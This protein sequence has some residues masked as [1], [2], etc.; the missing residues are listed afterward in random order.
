[1][2]SLPSA[3]RD[4]LGLLSLLLSLSTTQEC[5]GISP[6]TILALTSGRARWPGGSVRRVARFWARIV[7]RKKYSGSRSH[8]VLGEK[9]FGIAYDGVTRHQHGAT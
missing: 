2:R 3:S 5:D 8:R 4:L 7:R 6:V 1:M 9:D